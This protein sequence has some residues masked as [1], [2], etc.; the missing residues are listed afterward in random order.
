MGRALQFILIAVA[1]LFV[2][3]AAGAMGYFYFHPEKQE[4]ALAA[5]RKSVQQVGALVGV[6]DPV[7]TPKPEDDADKK[8]AETPVKSTRRRAPASKSTGGADAAAAAPKSARAVAPA[9][10]AAASSGAPS[11]T[12]SAAATTPGVRRRDVYLPG[13]VASWNR[14]DID[15]TAPLVIQA[16]GQL[17]IGTD[18]SGPEGLQTSRAKRLSVRPTDLPLPSAPYLG[19]I[20][21][22][23]SRRGCSEPFYVGTRS[24]LCPGVVGEGTLELWTNNRMLINGAPSRQNFSKTNGGFSIYADAA[25]ASACGGPDTAADVTGPDAAALAAGETL[26]RSEFRINSSQNAWKPFFLPLDRPVRIRATGTMR[27]RSNLDATGPEGIPVPQ[28]PSWSY[29]GSTQVVVDA[30]HPLVHPSMP[31]QALIGRVCGVDSCGAPFLVGRQRDVCAEPMYRNR[32]ELWINLIVMPLAESG[33]T[34]L[35]GLAQQARVGQYQFT[36]SAAPAGACGQ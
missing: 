8:A 31:Y 21:R 3:G 13:H 33:E 12:S 16:G 30:T 22:V 14:F 27:P 15:V 23:C 11:L 36:V 35:E 2:L 29:P 7:E 34:T 24:V 20:G 28:V 10:G 17:T 25:P 19:L 9:A 32:L 1:A 26:T 4:P 6:S 18:T 5:A